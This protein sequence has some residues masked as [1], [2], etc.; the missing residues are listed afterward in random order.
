M[1]TSGRSRIPQHRVAESIAAELRARILAD[2]GSYRLPTQDQLVQEFG[3]SYPSVREAIRILETEGLVTVRRGKVGGAEVHRPDEASAAYH[4]G[5]VLEG[6]RVTLRDLADGMQLLEPVCGAECARREDRAEA[7]IP[8]LRAN[9]ELSAGLVGD[10][11]AFNRVARE[12][13]D[14]VVGFTPSAT[15]RYLIS[16]LVALWSAQEET[17]AVAAAGRL[18]PS[19][20]EADSVVRDHRRITETIAAGN[21]EEARRLTRAHLAASQAL[22]LDH[23]DDGVVRAASAKARQSLP[24]TSYSRI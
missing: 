13:H 8:A 12:F 16:S 10:G 17:P 20:A 21:A 24:S 15:V 1:A 23:L 4:L 3:V 5:L 14:L 2:D 7:V 11:V 22:L 18:R 9:V 6:G 19:L